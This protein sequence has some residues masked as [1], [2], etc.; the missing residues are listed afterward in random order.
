M[1]NSAALS[2][3]RVFVAGAFVF[4]CGS[5]TSVPVPDERDRPRLAEPGTSSGSTAPTPPSPP[6]DGS[7]PDGSPP[8]ASVTPV[9]GFLPG[10]NLAGADFAAHVD[11][12]VVGTDYVYPRHEDIDYFATKGMKV[13]R[14]TFLWERLQ[15]QLDQPFFEDELA[16]LDDVVAYASERGLAVL[17]D[18]HNY[19]RYRGKVIGSDEEAAP[20][21]AQFGDFWSRLAA[22]YKDRPN[23]LFGIMNEPY[24]MDTQLWLEDANVA[25]AAIRSTGA[26]QAVFVPGTSWTG[27]HSW[28]SG[29]PGTSNAE[30]MLGVIDPLDNYVYEVHQYLDSDSSG[31]HRECISPTIGSE[32]LAGFTAWLEEHGQRGFLGEFAGSTDG[33]CLPALDDMLSF[34]DAHRSVWVGYT[35]WAGG[36]RWPDDDMFSVQP[37]TQDG[38]D[39]PQ[40]LELQKHL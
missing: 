35:Y 20:T 38:Q 4:A 29:E 1:K 7:S 21:K 36:P 19:A 33:P 25:I 39:R 10:V 17:L 30:V 28:R 12:G 9:A 22:Q 11:P 26:T 24:A 40:L 34:I 27:A 13:I 31:T 8:D 32:R 16:R 37:S 18:P 14:Q 2:W 15:R 23:V 6:Q 5:A 3:V